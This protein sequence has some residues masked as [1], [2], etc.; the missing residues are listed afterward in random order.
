M[1]NG[2]ITRHSR[3]TGNLLISA[4]PPNKIRCFARLTRG[5]GQAHISHGNRVNGLPGQ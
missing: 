5:T 4:A 2:P 3:E 1:A